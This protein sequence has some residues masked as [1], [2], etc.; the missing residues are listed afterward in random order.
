MDKPRIKVL[1]KPNRIIITHQGITMP[2]TGWCM[3]LGVDHRTF[4]HKLHSGRP[5]EEVFKPK[6]KIWPPGCSPE[7]LLFASIGTDTEF[8]ADQYLDLYGEPR[9]PWPKVEEGEEE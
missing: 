1:T 4:L 7:D 3:K 6:Q 5:M 9:R 8:T 2:V